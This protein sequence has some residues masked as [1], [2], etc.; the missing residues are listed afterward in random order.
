MSWRV[1][2]DCTKA[3]AEALPDA[4]DLFPEA[5]NPPVMV[6]EEPDPAKP[7]VWRLHAYFER[8]PGWDELKVIEAL[9]ADADPTIERLDEATDWVTVS[10]AGLDPI[11]AGRFF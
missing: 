2:L 10:Q 11:R 7:G 8:Q 6:T 4:N 5:D 3:E 1:S 9:A